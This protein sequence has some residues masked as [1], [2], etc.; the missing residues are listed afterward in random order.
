M[1]YFCN[2]TPS[3]PASRPL[4]PPS[5]PPSTTSATF[6]TRRPIFP[7]PS[8]ETTQCEDDKDEDLCNNLLLLNG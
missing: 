5:F 4:L 8:P 6:D 1:M 3:V 7:L 2:T